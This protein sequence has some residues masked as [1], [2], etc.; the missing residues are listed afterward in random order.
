[1]EIKDFIKKLKNAKKDVSVYSYD[2]KCKSIKNKTNWN[3]Y[4]FDICSK[5]K[6]EQT[7]G[8]YIEFYKSVELTIFQANLLYALYCLNKI[9]YDYAQYHKCIAGKE[10]IQNIKQIKGGEQI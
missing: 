7:K 2:Y 9:P 1:M 3:I 5:C 10:F 6:R 8:V 4:S